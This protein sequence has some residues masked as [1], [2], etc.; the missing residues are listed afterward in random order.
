MNNKE[1]RISINKPAF[2]PTRSQSE[3]L[4]AADELRRRIAKR[5]G[6]NLDCSSRYVREDR[7]R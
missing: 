7:E 4:K 3:T 6:A 2:P 1:N 5:L